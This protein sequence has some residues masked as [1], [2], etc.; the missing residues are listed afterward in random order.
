MLLQNSLL[1]RVCMRLGVMN[2]KLSVRFSWFL[3]YNLAFTT[4]VLRLFLFPWKI[5]HIMQA[6][7]VTII[8]L[9]YLVHASARSERL[10]TP[11]EHAKE[12]CSR[13]QHLRQRRG[14]RLRAAGGLEDGLGDSGGHGESLPSCARLGECLCVT[15]VFDFH[16][17][18]HSGLCPIPPYSAMAQI[19]ASNHI[20]V[21]A[22]PTQ[23]LT[24]IWLI[25]DFPA[26]ETNVHASLASPDSACTLGMERSAGGERWR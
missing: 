5:T 24:R 17:L 15:G 6:Y 22:E 3:K 9:R 2:A 8:Y 16:N 4:D 18:I 23:G 26:C 11:V 14:S 21:A 19:F 25:S 12:A 13:Q 7:P 1:K 10:G 20:V